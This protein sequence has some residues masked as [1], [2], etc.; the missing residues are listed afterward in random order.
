MARPVRLTG[1]GVVHHV[2]NRRVMWLDLFEKDADYAAFE[3]VLASTPT[4]RYYYDGVR[5]IQEV[6]AFA[7]ALQPWASFEA[8]YADRRRQGQKVITRLRDP[9]ERHIAPPPTT[10]PDGND[11]LPQEQP[12]EG[13]GQRLQIIIEPPL[14]SA[15][16]LESSQFDVQAAGVVI[17]GT[18]RGR[19]PAVVLLHGGPGCC[20]YFAGS[21]LAGWLAEGHAVC[22]YDQRGC[23]HSPSD[24]PFTIEANVEDLEAVRRWIGADR[25]SVLGHSAGAILALFYAATY[26]GQV[27]RM[28]L[29]S[30]AGLRPGWRPAFEATIRERLTPSQERQLADIDRRIMKTA[31][32]AE[33]ARLYHE[34]FNAALPCYVDPSHRDAAPALEH[35]NREV[36]LQVTASIQQ[37]YHEAEFKRRLGRYQG[38]ACIIHGRSDPVPWRVV[39]DLAAIV[40]SAEVVALDQCGHFPWLEEPAACRAAL[41][42]FLTRSV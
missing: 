6:D 13:G 26:P 18:K 22:S 1:P 21:A 39:E 4:T 38:P 29:M 16:C 3:G 40:P 17:H 23:R 20:D 34:R 33:R 9:A 42:D 8:G 12:L 31:D 37:A 30:P 14:S 32:Q 24:G 11:E 27:E 25:I 41:V 2:L 36:N 19:G 35:Y 28:A 10:E 15:M 7:A 5:L